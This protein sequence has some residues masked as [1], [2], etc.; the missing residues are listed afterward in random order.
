MRD[1]QDPIALPLVF[2]TSFALLIWAN[3][4]A[5]AAGDLRGVLAASTGALGAALVLGQLAGRALRRCQ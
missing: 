5:A 2:L 4:D 3:A 1:Y